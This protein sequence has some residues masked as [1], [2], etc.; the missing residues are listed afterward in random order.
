CPLN[1]VV[2]I[3]KNDMDPTVGKMKIYDSAD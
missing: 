1:W 2:S 3:E